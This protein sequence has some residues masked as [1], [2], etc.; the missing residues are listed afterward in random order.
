MEILK[1]V[2]PYAFFN[3]SRT[4]P[5]GHLFRPRKALLRERYQN[6]DYRREEQMK[7]ADLAMIFLYA[8]FFLN[9]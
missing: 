7:N 4:V 6:E 3:P 2:V 5:T 8:I 1:F 9:V